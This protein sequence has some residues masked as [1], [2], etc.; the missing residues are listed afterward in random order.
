MKYIVLQ[1]KLMFTASLV[2]VLSFVALVV[3][4]AGGALQIFAA[5]KVSPVYYLGLVSWVLLIWASYLGIRMGSY[6]LY[7]GEYRKLALRIILVIV[8][9]GIGLITG[10]VTGLIIAV[11]IWASLWSLKRNYDDRDQTG[12][13]WK[14]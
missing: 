13:S 1:T 14:D 10:Y 5:L 2:R 7:P 11:I 9:A 6:K 12:E 3:C 4:L 8:A